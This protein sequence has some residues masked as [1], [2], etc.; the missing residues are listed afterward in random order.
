MYKLLF[1]ILGFITGT[2]LLQNVRVLIVEDFKPLCEHLSE[3]LSCFE[4]IQIIGLAANGAEA[5]KSCAELLPDVVLMDINMP[6]MNGLTAT[7]LIRQQFPHTQVVIL[8]LTPQSQIRSDTGAY[9]YLE[10]TSVTIESLV[11]TLK[12][13][14]A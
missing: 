4:G 9:A 7:H 6:L 14:P 8:T 12:A 3:L 1:F 5:L 10:K 11:D 2:N 13:V